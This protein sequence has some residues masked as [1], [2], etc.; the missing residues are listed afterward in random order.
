[1]APLEKPLDEKSYGGG[2]KTVDN[3]GLVLTGAAVAG[4]A[5]HAVATAIRHKGNDDRTQEG[6]HD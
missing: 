5:V 3:I 2:E 1:M 4:I 6:K